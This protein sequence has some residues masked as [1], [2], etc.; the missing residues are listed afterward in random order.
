MAL[1]DNCVSA[2]SASRSIHLCSVKKNLC[3]PFTTCS[4]ASCH[5]IG[6]LNTCVSVSRYFCNNMTDGSILFG[7]PSFLQL[8][9]D[10]EMGTLGE[11]HP[12][13]T[14]TSVYTPVVE[15]GVW[16]PLGG[17]DLRSHGKLGN[18][19]VSWVLWVRPRFPILPTVSGCN[20]PARNSPHLVHSCPWEATQICYLSL[21]QG[22]VQESDV[23][24]PSPGTRFIH[25]RL[26]HQ[27]SPPGGSDW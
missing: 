16:V 20:V 26:V 10:L 3:S 15:Q 8:G 21:C 9:P 4:K 7:S 6:K 11:T 5:F 12:S 14:L 18:P 23:Q 22:E 17:L 25:T 24:N 1:K 27:A 13:R 19:G 2:T